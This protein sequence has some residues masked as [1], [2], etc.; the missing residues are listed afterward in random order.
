MLNATVVILLAST[1]QS[2]LKQCGLKGSVAK[3]KPYI[4]ETN[5]LKIPKF[6]KE[7]VNRNVVQWRN[8]IWLNETK[9]NMISSY[10]GVYVQRKHSKAAVRQRK[11]NIYE[12]H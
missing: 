1:V 4:S 3:N 8:V 11:Y 2:C 9:Y 10:G 12:E 6:A 7:Y 5:Q